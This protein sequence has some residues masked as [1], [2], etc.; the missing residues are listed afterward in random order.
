MITTGS[1]S[2]EAATETFEFLAPN[3]RGRRN[4][5]RAFTHAAPEFVFWI[6][7]DGELLDARDAHRKNPPEN[8][9]WILD[10]EPDYGGFLRGR[11]ARRFDQQ[12][13]VIYCRSELL[14]ESQTA[15]TQLIDGLAQMP[16]PI[17]ENALVV[18]DNADIYG[19]VGDL[20]NR[21]LEREL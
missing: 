5:M 13:I 19:T 16:I 20:Q 14:S 10:D 15:M 21:S 6:A 17:D 18:S 2:R 8:Y 12:L 4:A 11:V 3:F 1:I 9:E 7:P